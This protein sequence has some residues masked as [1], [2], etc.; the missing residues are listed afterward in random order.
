M[1]HAWLPL[2]VVEA[3]VPAMRGQQV[4]EV[5]RGDAR[6]AATGIGFLDAYRAARGSPAAMANLQATARTS[7]TQRREGFIARHV[8]QARRQGE[9]WWENGAPTRRH[10]AL[11]AWAYSPTPGKIRAWVD[12]QDAIPLR[13]NAGPR[14]VARWYR[15]HCGMP[16]A[17]TLKI[18]GKKYPRQSPRQALSPEDLRAFQQAAKQFP[19]PMREALILLPE[20]GLRVAEVCALRW[21]WIRRGSMSVLGKGSKWRDVALTPAARAILQRTPR[22]TDRVFGGLTP[23]RV[24]RACRRI[25]AMVRLS[26]PLTP[27]VLRHTYA[28]RLVRACTPLR[29]VQALLGHDSFRTTLVYL[30]SL[31]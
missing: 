11:V 1:T 17:E 7:W 19:S 28:T 29:E 23:G 14:A 27:H 26:V 24:Q 10:L 5:A 2:A 18:T 4:S 13:R 15:C 16:R 8:A 20:T 31:T 30:H 3:A 6:S 21:A 9:P 25:E 12:A 22:G